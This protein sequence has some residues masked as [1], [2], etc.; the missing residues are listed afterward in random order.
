METSGWE[1][2]EEIK[3]VVS[4]PLIRYKVG[5]PTLKGGCQLGKEI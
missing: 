5:Y 3:P 2:H 4:I 1:V